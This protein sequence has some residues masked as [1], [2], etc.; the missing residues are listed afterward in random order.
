MNIA[1]YFSTDSIFTFFQSFIKNN[2]AYIHNSDF[3][4]NQ[5][6]ITPDI[7]NGLFLHN[8]IY[9]NDNH[10]H[11]LPYKLNIIHINQ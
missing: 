2:R 6:N 8:H 3:I 4:Q 10:E 9:S 11:N 1:Q 7:E 5:F